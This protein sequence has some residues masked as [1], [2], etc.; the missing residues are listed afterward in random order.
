[1]ISSGERRD[2]PARGIGLSIEEV[3]EDAEFHA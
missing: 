3:I 1:V 2:Y